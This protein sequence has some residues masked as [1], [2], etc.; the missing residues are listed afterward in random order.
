MRGPDSSFPAVARG[1]GRLVRTFEAEIGRQKKLIA[2]AAGTVAASV[3]FQL[4]EP[5]PLKFI[6]DLLFGVLGQDGRRAAHLTAGWSAGET[7]A[8]GAGAMIALA[9][10]AAAADYGNAVLLALAASRILADIR[11]RVFGHIANLSISF[12]NRSRAGDLTSRVIFDIDRIREVLVTA[13]VPFVSNSLALAAMVAVMF[14]MNWRLALIAV[15]AFPVFVWAVARLTQKIRE[16]T[17]TQRQKEGA[18][19]ATAAEVMGS[20]R[21]VQALS[22][23]RHFERV[24][25]ASNQKSLTTG[26]ETQR[27]SAKLE[28]TA[29]LLA[30]STGALVL[31]AG[32]HA[33]LDKSITPGEL[34]VFLNYLRV[35]FKPLRQL[36]KYL[37]QMAKA[38]ASGD[39]ILDVLHTETEVKDREG[40]R[41]AP[42]LRGHVKFENVC[43]EY[44]AGKPVIEGVSFEARPGERVAIVGE[45]GSGKSTL[46]SLLLRFHEATS[47]RILV[48]GTPVEDYTIDSLRRQVSVV[49]QDSVLFA[50]SVRENIALG[51]GQA[52][53][54]E[55]ERAARTANAHEFIERMPRGYET[56]LGERGATVSGGQRQRI[57]I[58]RAAIRNAPVVVLDEP[59]TGLDEA[60]AREVE[61]GLERLWKGRTTILITHELEAAR[62]ADRVLYLRRG[63][64]VEQGTF[65]ELMAKDGAFAAMYGRRRGMREEERMMALDV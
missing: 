50:A 47:G 2:A 63:R 30:S 62:G 23:Q 59:A 4:L 45:S 54:E 46:A 49:M 29:E 36:A 17:R 52:S 14:W 57:A 44:E 55:V 1:L 18:M 33:V 40:A 43:F 8:A 31:W 32:A 11:M 61:A 6:Y 37:G 58:A 60:G 34:I 10:L 27:L 13:V 9:G 24:F 5:W 39:R 38:V 21:I 16:T 19:A 7:I 42:A 15:G 65:E 48:D 3:A 64:V 41:K 20:I 28:R 35:S 51:A 12:H 56:E 25:S 26:V 53:G 22:L